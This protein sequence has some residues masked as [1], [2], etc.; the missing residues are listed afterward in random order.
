M[1]VGNTTMGTS[2]V[3]VIGWWGKIQEIRGSLLRLHP[4]PPSVYVELDN[5]GT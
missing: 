3:C 1:D 2:L 4:G 5:L